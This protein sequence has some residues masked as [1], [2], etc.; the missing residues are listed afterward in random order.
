VEIPVPQ[1]VMELTRLDP[2]DLA[3]CSRLKVLPYDFW[4]LVRLK[5]DYASVEQGKFPHFGSARIRH[6][7]AY[8]VNLSEFATGGR[9]Q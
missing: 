5:Y 7:R 9:M 6:M 1:A 2:L 4:R 8:V 3:L